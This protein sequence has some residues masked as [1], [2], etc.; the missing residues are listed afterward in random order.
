MFLN[1]PYEEEI[2][3][4]SYADNGLLLVREHLRVETEGTCTRLLNMVFA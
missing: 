1:L 4:K 3:A 2:T